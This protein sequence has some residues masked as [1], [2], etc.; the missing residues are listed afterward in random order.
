MPFQIHEGGLSGLIRI[1]SRLFPD[2]RGWFAE[3]FQRGVFAAAGIPTEFPQDN[4]S[5][6]TRGVLRGLHFQRDPES[7]GKLVTVLQGEVFDVAVDLREGSPT[8]RQWRGF[9]LNALHPTLLYI[10]EGFAHGFCV[11]SDEAIFLYKCTREYAPQADGGICWNDPE[12]AVNWPLE[13]PIVSDKDR[14][15]PRLGDAKTG[16][17]YRA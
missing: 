7:Q 3:V 9:T 5:Y 12:L 2:S 14:A 10:P 6:S 11:L 13:N 8:Y 1:E 4:V 16:F 17:R 15:L